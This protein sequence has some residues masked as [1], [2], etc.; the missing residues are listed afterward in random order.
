M[1]QFIKHVGLDTHKATIAVAV[2]DACPV[3]RLMS[4]IRKTALTESS[5][6]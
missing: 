1:N 3:F 6:T 4:A 2:A 5:T